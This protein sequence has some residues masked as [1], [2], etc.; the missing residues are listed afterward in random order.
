MLKRYTTEE[1]SFF[2]DT[3]HAVDYLLRQAGFQTH[4]S[5]NVIDP[6]LLNIIWGANAHGSPTL[7]QIRAVARPEFSII[8]NMEQIALGNSFVTMDY[9]NFLSEYRVLDYNHR[10]IEAMHSYLPQIDAF[11]FPVLPSP[12]MASDFS[13]SKGLDP[14][15]FDVAFWGA[16]SDRRMHVLQQLVSTGHS[17]KYI[18]GAFGRNLSTEIYDS[19]I[20]LNI[21]AL[22][23]GI[24]E[25]ARCL[26]PLSMGMPVVSEMSHTPRLVDWTN[27]GIFFCQYDELAEKCHELIENPSL[28]NEALR[29]TQH[30]IYDGEWS[31]QARKIIQEL[32][33]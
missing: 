30:F 13:V 22:D 29:K 2:D 1:P 4:V 20:C 14:N 21:H 15:K 7:D 18:G 3:V 23:T 24:F 12:L 19:N 27:S 32:C 28:V 17:V 16:K 31:R 8:F 33:K 26:R 9:L 10:N 25:I 5:C 11:E 6:G